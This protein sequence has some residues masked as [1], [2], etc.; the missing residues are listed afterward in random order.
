V[1]WQQHRNLKHGRLYRD[2]ENPQRFAFDT[3]C[4]AS[5]HYESEI[6]SG[7]YDAEV[8]FT[9][10]RVTNA[11]LDGWT[12]T[13]AGWH[14]AL[15]IPGEGELAGLDGVVGFGGRKGQN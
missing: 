11:Q 4:G 10:N 5:I 6:D 14:Y 3:L 1:A 13:Q 15:G 7:N 12:V 8:D 2:S 9:P